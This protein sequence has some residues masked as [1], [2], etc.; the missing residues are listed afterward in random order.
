MQRQ[1]LTKY[2]LSDHNFVV[3]TGRH[4]KTWL[5]KEDRACGH[6]LTEKFETEEHKLRQK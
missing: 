4:R 3:E 2:R 6:G 5:P 1:I